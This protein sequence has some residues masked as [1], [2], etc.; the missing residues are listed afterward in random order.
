LPV[1]AREKGGRKKEILSPFYSCL[2]SSATSVE[3]NNFDAL[4]VVLQE[5]KKKKRGGGRLKRTKSLLRFAVLVRGTLVFVLLSRKRGKKGK[6]K[7]RI[8]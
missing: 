1:F 5:G 8:T 2:F 3:G 6:R 7:K 4:G